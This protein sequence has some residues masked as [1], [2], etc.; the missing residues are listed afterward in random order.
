MKSEVPRRSSDFHPF[1]ACCCLLPAGAAATAKPGRSTLDNKKG[2]NTKTGSTSS[3][4]S[5]LTQNITLALTLNLALTVTNL[6][7]T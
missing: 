6:I 2:L 4:P 5:T 1:H 3:V 7:L